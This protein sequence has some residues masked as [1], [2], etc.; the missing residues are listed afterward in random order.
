MVLTPIFVE[1]GGDSY[2]FRGSRFPGVDLCNMDGKTD[3]FHVRL[4]GS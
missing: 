2:K 1:K 4:S 3:S